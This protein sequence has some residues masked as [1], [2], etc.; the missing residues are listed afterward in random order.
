MLAKIISVIVALSQILTSFSLSVF[1]QQV[2]PIDYGGTKYVAPVITDWLTLVNNGESDYV[3]IKGA[4][5]SPSE[6]TA[7]AELQNYINQISGKTLEIKTDAAAVSSHEIIVGRTNREGKDSFMI[8]RAALGDEGFRVMVIGEKLIIAGGELRGTLYGVYTFLEQDLG[9]RWFTPEVTVIP[10]NATVKI[11]ATL[12][13][14]QKPVFEYRYTDW[15]CTL[16][17]NWRVKQKMNEGADYPEYG[18]SLFYANGCHSMSSLLPDTYFAAHPEY[19]SYRED[20]GARTLDQRCLTNPDVLAIVT[21]SV[22]EALL[23]SPRAKIVSITQNDNGG[24]CQCPNC[25]AMDEKYGGPAGTNIWFV[26]QIAAALQSE[27]PNVEFDTFA[28]Q[29]TRTPPKNIVPRD[30]VVV[31]LCSIECCFAHPL[32]ECGIS[33][34]KSED[35][36]STFPYIELDSPAARTAKTPS[37]FASDMKGWAAISKNLY[38]WDYTTNFLMYLNI[39]ANF[40]VLSPNMQFFANNNVKGVFEEGNAASKS[41][42]FGELRAYIIA[43]LLW[44]PNADVEYLMNDFLKG[45]YGEKSA[46]DI[47]DYIDII[48][49][50][51]LNTHQHL[52]IFQWQYEGLYFTPKERKHIDALWDDAEKNAGSAQQLENIQRSRL[53]FRVYKANLFMDEFSLLNPLKHYNENKKL[54]NDIVSHGITYMTL[55]GPFSTTPNYW[56]TPADW[57]T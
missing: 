36:T 28:Y 37:A 23:A 47:K 55:D 32:E 24:Y 53:S 31:R 48:T 27:F 21:Q 15:N 43:K 13:Y 14:S 30:N 8:D 9:C 44:N 20:K 17:E 1:N 16:D 7:A 29:Y 38:A 33:R 10:H 6:T 2:K 25:K 54:Y 57:I 5:C 18:G 41:G 56:L 39:F 19:F 35:R 22:R 49:N 42:E 46:Q 34:I 26:N 11:D 51:T 45:Y 3:I 50:K 40:Q 4:A 52:Y 12:N